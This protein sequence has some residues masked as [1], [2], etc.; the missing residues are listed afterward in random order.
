VVLSKVALS[1]CHPILAANL[2]RRGS[3]LLCCLL[4]PVILGGCGDSTNEKRLQQDQIERAKREAAHQARVEER[5]R[6][7][8]RELKREVA[9]L[10]H[11]RGRKGS[12]AP[13]TGSAPVQP[14]G[15]HSCGGGLY[16]GPNTS[17][18]FAENVRGA[19]A[20]SGGGNVTV[21]AFSP[22]T[23]RDF[24]M[25]CTGGSPHVCTGGNNASVYFP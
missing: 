16:V 23:D 13:A 22:A 15:T 12:A 8:T 7:Q 6:Q 21:T 4:V 17:C 11:D 14:G 5:Q 2:R 9:K 25:S 1:G 24:A 19:Y 20:G 18:G 3:A 10:K